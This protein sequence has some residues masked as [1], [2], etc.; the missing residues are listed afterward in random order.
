M[1]RLLGMQKTQEHSLL[2]PYCPGTQF[3]PTIL[4]LT[5]AL[6]FRLLMED[7]N[8]SMANVLLSII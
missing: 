4:L 2:F 3:L 5:V 8:V 7:T 6:D 1:P